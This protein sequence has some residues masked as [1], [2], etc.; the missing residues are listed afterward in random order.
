M[1][2]EI[3]YRLDASNDDSDTDQPWMPQNGI[4]WLTLV[5]RLD[6]AAF[7]AASGRLSAAHRVWLE[8]FLASRDEA[9]RNHLMRETLVLEPIP[10][11]LSSL[12]AQFADPLRTLMGAVGLVLLIAC[13]N[14]ASLLLARSVA[15][16]HEMAVRVSL[17]ARPGR[18]V[19]QTLTESLALAVLGGIVG[20]GLAGFGAR[21]M[22]RLASRGSSAIPLDISLDGRVLGFVAAVTLLTGLLFGLA[23]A[24]RSVRTDLHD[25]FKTGGRVVGGTSGRLPLGRLLVVAQIALSLVL[26]AGA[27]LFVRTLSSLLATDPGFAREEIVSAGIDTRAAGYRPSDLPGIYQRLLA[28]VERIPGVRSASLSVY[29]FASRAIRSSGMTVPGRVR[30]PSWDNSVQEVFV[31]PAFFSTVGV[32]LLRGRDFSEADRL[33]GNRVAIVSESLARHFLDTVDVVGQRIG[34]GTPAEFEIVG[35]V[36]DAQANSL[37]EPPP[38]IIYYPMAQG[39]TEYAT[40]LEARVAGPP[41]QMVPAIRAAIARVDRGLPVRE[42]ATLGDLMA[43][44]LRTERLVA[45]LAGAFSVLALLLAGIGLYGVVAYSVSRR[46][47]EMG[48][49]LALGARP[50]AVRWIVLRDSWTMIGLG[51][52]AGALLWVPSFAVVRNLVHG[53]PARDP[54]SLALAIGLLALVGTIAALLP[55]W[56]A[57]RVDPS[58]ALRTE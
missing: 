20:L 54:V 47:N 13:A 43:S 58:A 34:Y 18:L 35:V 22:L 11:G 44:G 5:T 55:A 41:E 28:E 24:L 36:R 12:R 40:S 3:G 10:R 8:D 42:V 17:G 26:A 9:E 31:T 50:G 37:K 33:P 45:T 14:L 57:S 15:R 6:P 1:Q 32:P 29:G 38:R 4:A 19:R 2:H 53:V 52:A 21:A 30:D 49:R 39:P 48:V 7:P 27:G 51:V 56:R 23:P 25:A 46:I 16:T